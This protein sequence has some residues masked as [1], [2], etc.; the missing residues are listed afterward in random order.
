VFDGFWASPLEAGSPAAGALRRFAFA[1]HGHAPMTS[2]GRTLAGRHP[3]TFHPPGVRL[4]LGCIRRFRLRARLGVA[5]AGRGHP[6]APLSRRCRV[7]SVRGPGCGLSPPVCL[8]MPGATRPPGSLGILAW[9]GEAIPGGG[10]A[11]IPIDPG[12]LRCSGSRPLA[13]LDGIGPVAHHDGGALLPTPR[14][15][16][17]PPATGKNEGPSV[18]PRAPRCEHGPLVPPKGSGPLPTTVPEEPPGQTVTNG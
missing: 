18:Q 1:R 9:A 7:P 11:R 4:P 10:G 12:G 5:M 8:V 15:R 14:V 13:R 16:R 17:Q 3:T 6:T 2:T